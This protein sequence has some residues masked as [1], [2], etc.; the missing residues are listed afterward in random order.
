[1]A[2]SGRFV[3]LALLGLIPVALLPGWGSAALVGLLL[4][5]SALLDLALAVPLRQ[6][7]VQRND[8]GS[9]PLAGQ[10]ESVLTVANAGRR[11][12][13]GLVRDA[14][15]PSAGARNPVQP[16]VVPPGERR[17][18]TVTLQPTRRGELA[19]AHVT[20]RAFGPLGLAAR[21]RTFPCPGTLRVLPPF[22]SRRHLPS[23]LRRRRGLDGLAAV[24][25]RGAGT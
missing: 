21:Q 2:V 4:L 10:T 16:L 7:S 6:V 17:R 24:L 22:Y 14:W 12:L 15:Q 25:I 13:R 20:V 3:V 19:A 23:K 8:A 11:M 1:M 9:V 18:I 5:A